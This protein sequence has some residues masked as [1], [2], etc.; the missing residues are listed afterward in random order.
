MF[1][2]KKV[3]ATG[4]FNDD[5]L[6]L[7]KENICTSINSGCGFLLFA[8]H[9]FPDG[10]G[11]HP[12]S[13]FGK[14][15]LPQPF[16]RPSFFN[17]SDIHMLTNTD[18]LPIAV[19]SACSCGDF[20][21][22]PHPFAWAFVQHDSG[23]ICSFACTTLGTLLPTSL[24]TSTMNGKLS[25]AVFEAY[26][27]GILRAGDIWRYSISSYLNDPDAMSIG[28]LPGLYWINNFNLEEWI[29]F[30]DPTLKIGGYQ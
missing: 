15:W 1:T 14:L 16:F 4:F 25:L 30:G 24:C 18:M 12:P 2:T 8:G 23:A 13:L 20:N 28:R 11:T 19:I 17:I 7:T 26:D 5:A 9:G 6:A 10:W 22:T 3:Y 27:Q 21:T 29:L